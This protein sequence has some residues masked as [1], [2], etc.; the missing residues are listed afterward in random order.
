LAL[1]VWG[2]SDVLVNAE[3]GVGI[4]ALLLEKPFTTDLLETTVRK[5]LVRPVGVSGSGP[6]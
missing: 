6:V 2:Y 5:A 1:A 4:G 3:A